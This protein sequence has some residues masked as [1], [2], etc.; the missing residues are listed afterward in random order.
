[1]PCKPYAGPFNVND[2]Y[3]SIIDRWIKVYGGLTNLN[4]RKALDMAE[5]D[6]NDFERSLIE[7]EESERK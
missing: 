5:E 1:M 7:Y 4:P 6:V 3:R 2:H